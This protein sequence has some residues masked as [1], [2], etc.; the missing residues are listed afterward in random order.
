MSVLKGEGTVPILFGSTS[1]AAGSRLHTGYLA[2]P[3][4]EGE[5]P[6]V[7]V[8]PS[9]WGVTSS[10]KDVC[11]RLARRGLAAIAPDLYRGNGPAGDADRTTA[12]SVSLPRERALADLRDVVRFTTNP[13]GFWSSAEFGFGLLGLGSGGP[14]AVGLAG[15][16]GASA[17]ALVHAPLDDDDVQR[18]SAAAVPVLGLFGR[19]DEVV[20]IDTV[21]DARSHLPH[22]EFAVYDGVGHDFLDDHRDGYDLDAA[23]DAIER[24]TEFF[25]KQ[26]PPR[27]V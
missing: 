20:S 1:I 4:L 12:M 21:I 10:V 14:L 7:V 8:V 5:W 16:D 2:R 24:L 15:V 27:L 11:R 23:Q 17:I 13:A 18:L 26:L 25:T 6:T 3:D 19:D 9:V 22:A